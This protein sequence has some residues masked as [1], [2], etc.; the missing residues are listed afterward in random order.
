VIDAFPASDSAKSYLELSQKLLCLPMRQD[1]AEG[2]ISSIIQSLMRQV[3]QPLATTGWQPS[4][5]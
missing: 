1:E 3:S 4:L 5:F 2:G